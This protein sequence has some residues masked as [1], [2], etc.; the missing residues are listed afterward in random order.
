MEDSK[1]VNLRWIQAFNERDWATETFCRAPEFVAHVTGAPGPLNGADWVGFLS[2]FATG[3]PDAQI[4]VEA[5][6]AERDLV[7]T[8][9]TITGTHRGTFQGIP[10]TGRQVTMAG[11]EFTRVVDGKVAE[12]WVQFDVPG[13]MQQIGGLQA[14]A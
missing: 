6:I 10:A 3:V 5:S 14:A 1:S 11:I 4:Y 9:W 12:H 7:A 2:A 8:R 13:L